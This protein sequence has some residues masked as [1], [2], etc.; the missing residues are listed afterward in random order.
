MYLNIQTQYYNNQLHVGSLA[1][2]VG[3][4]RLRRE[5]AI[6]LKSIII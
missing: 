1:K 2:R 6:P 4:S 3:L 5:A